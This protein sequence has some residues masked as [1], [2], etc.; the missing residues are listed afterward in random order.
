MTETNR[1]NRKPLAYRVTE[2]LFLAFI[3]LY[4]LKLDLVTTTFKL[5]LPDHIDRLLIVL[6]AAAA[7]ARLAAFLIS[8]RSDSRRWLVWIAAALVT[9]AVY[10][11]V[12]M[13]HHYRIKIELEEVG[14]IN[15]QKV[16]KLVRRNELSE[17]LNKLS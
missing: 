11:M 9:D 14:K 8:S 17:N 7:M 2:D 10:F 12:Y 1:I 15:K 3:G 4:L 13:E 16:Y 5:K 6:L